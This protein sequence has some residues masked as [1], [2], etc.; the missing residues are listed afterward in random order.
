MLLGVLDDDTGKLRLDLYGPHGNLPQFDP[1]RDRKAGRDSAQCL[2]AQEG[3]QYEGDRA[4]LSAL[5]DQL[6]DQLDTLGHVNAGLGQ[7]DRERRRRCRDAIFGR[8]L[9]CEHGN[10]LRLTGKYENL[11]ADIHFLLLVRIREEADLL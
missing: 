11:P 1:L 7:S 3:R 8:E 5:L 10:H 6:L 4:H 9:L 2:A